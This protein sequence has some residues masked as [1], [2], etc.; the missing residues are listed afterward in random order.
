[1]IMTRS[2]FVVVLFVLPYFL[3]GQECC[4]DEDPPVRRCGHYEYI[5]MLTE[6]DPDFPA[7]RA[8]IEQE[9]LR[10]L[11]ENGTE[12][13]SGVNNVITIP[14][15]VHILYY[16]QIQNI[17]HSRVL[18]QIETL[19]KDFRK[20]NANLV[21][22]PAAFVNRVADV[23]FEFCLAQRDPQGNWTNGVTRRQVSQTS[24]TF[25]D[26]NIIKSTVNGG[27]SIWDRSRYLNIWVVNLTGGVLGYAQPPGG[28]GSTDGLVICYRYFGNTG[29]T[30]PFN[31]GR[32][33]VHEVGHWFNLLH[34]WGDDNGACWGSDYVND[35]PNQASEFYGCPTFP[36]MDVC[37]PDSPGVMF[38][39]YMDYV[40][41]AC[42][43][44]FT[45]GQKSRMLAALNVFRAGL[46]TSNGC[47]PAIGIDEIPDVSSMI[48]YPNPGDGLFHLELL[49]NVLSDVNVSVYNPV[50]QLVWHK[51]IQK[52]AE[53]HE[54][55][56]V[57][58]LHRGVY[59]LE[60]V[61]GTHRSTHKIV[62]R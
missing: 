3:Q 31:Q 60:I 21:N 61:A 55:I 46:K 51:Q 4:A 36:Q 52:A 45:N 41:D 30:P 32:T 19:N 5:H 50:G 56:D 47:Q 35:T 40:D 59:F 12:S 25:N 17:P 7:R 1:M 9:M 37:T 62:I 39:N 8:E 10:W 20:L 28:P 6:Q 44:M 23:E 34:I 15:V 27:Q 14:V 38:M 57:R 2:W 18:E 48:V 54:T 16:N 58:H 29:A 33:T 26:D 24:F 43:M 42:M 11:A 49:M 13:Q 22:V 53:I